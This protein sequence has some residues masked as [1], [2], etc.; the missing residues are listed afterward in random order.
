MT[1][2]SQASFQTSIVTDKESTCI[3]LHTRNKELFLFAGIYN[4]FAIDWAIKYSNLS[5]EQVI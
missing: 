5:R 4:C 3:C 2:I 1:N